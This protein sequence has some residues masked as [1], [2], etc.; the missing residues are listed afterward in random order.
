[1]CRWYVILFLLIFLLHFISQAGAEKKPIE[2]VDKAQL[3]SEK[4]NKDGERLDNQILNLN[5]KIEEVVAKYK[6]LSTK[7]IRVLPYRITYRLGK[8]YIEIET[9]KFH[10]DIFGDNRI[11]GIQTKRSRLFVSGQ[12][13]SKMEFEIGER[14]YDIES[15]VVVRIVD[16]SPTVVGTDDVVFSHINGRV[17]L[18]D[19]K[20]LGK[21]RNNMAFPVRNSLKRDFLI[22]HLT[23]V[24]NNLLSIAETYYKGIKD[25]DRAMT[26]FI[27]RAIEY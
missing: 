12:N 8:D 11:T 15:N 4:L 22:P 14:Q 19:E 13:V 3:E 26:N 27:I 24:Y 2:S 21:I 7:D 25:A 1:M 5:K 16:P 18:I 20:A 23:F 17:K 6:L 9:Y 10:R